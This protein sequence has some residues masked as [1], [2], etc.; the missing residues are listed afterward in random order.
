M[1]NLYNYIKFIELVSLDKD[2]SVN[3]GRGDY[4]YKL[5]NFQ[6]DIAQLYSFNTYSSSI[7]L[8]FR[9]YMLDTIRDVVRKIY[10]KIK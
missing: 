10:Y 4:R 6:S 2:V 3:F 7:D 8:L 1:I 5:S 9:Y